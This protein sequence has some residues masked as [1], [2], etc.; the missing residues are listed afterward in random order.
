[1]TVRR[2]L[3]VVLAVA[4]LAGTMP[5]AVGAVDDSGLDSSATPAGEATAVCDGVS[6]SGNVVVATLSST[7]ERVTGSAQLYANVTL[8]LRLC[9]S[10]GLVTPYGDAWKLQDDAG[11][12]VVNET[13][14]GPRVRLEPGYGSV[15]FPS[16]V[17]MKQVDSGLTVTEPAANAVDPAIGVDERLYLPSAGSVDEYLSRERAFVDASNR[18]S[19]ATERLA[20]TAA[21]LNGSGSGSFNAT[22][23]NRT[24][25]RL[26]ESVDELNASA[27]S[28]RTFLFGVTGESPT[29]G[30]AVDTL[31]AVESSET[32]RRERATDA[33]A[34]Y[35]AALDAR[36]RSLTSKI[37][38]NL[39]LATGLGLVLG[40]LGGGALPYL[41][42]N[43]TI[44]RKRIDSTT[45]Y[46]R[47]A[48]WVPVGGGIALVAA[49]LVVV[50][51]TA[52]LSLFGVI[53]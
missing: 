22:T 19:A 15:E 28:F 27:S 2:Y 35:D 38:N 20:E 24:L 45:D 48:L 40:V 44:G 7:G 1:M 36:E 53:L 10:E 46:N 42:A 31:D 41:V 29:P 39:L 50:A 12:E 34:A 51:L 49:T 14:R 47:Y 11:F 3:A 18:T 5:A 17:R 25:D 30:V 26:D 16:K 52:G 37:R 8:D 13:D 21:A 33:V 32:T 43:R 9:S 4:V 23:A 6:G